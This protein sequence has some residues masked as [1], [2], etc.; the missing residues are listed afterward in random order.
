[1]ELN[2][3]WPATCLHR[4]R[5]RLEV[6][7]FGAAVDL[8]RECLARAPARMIHARALAVLG[9]AIGLSNGGSSEE[10]E[11]SLGESVSLCDSMGIFPYLAEAHH[12]LAELF[13]HRGDSQRAGYYARRAAEGFEACGMPVHA[14]LARREDAS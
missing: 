7:E 5:G 1:M 11:W 6:G 14:Q 9:L 2:D 4:A 13:Q 12:F 3:T 8:G 10:A